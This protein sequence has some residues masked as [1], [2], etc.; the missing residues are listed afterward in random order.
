MSV[1]ALQSY[2]PKIAAWLNEVAK[3]DLEAL[4]EKLEAMCPGTEM[5][6]VRFRNINMM[7]AGDLGKLAE[8]E[9]AAYIDAIASL[10]EAEIVKYKEKTD[11]SFAEKCPGF[12]MDASTFQ[13]EMTFA[14]SPGFSGLPS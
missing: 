2:E 1:Q 6:A 11:I 8:P 7:I 9:K 14:F 5:T 3:V 12:E 10:D 4:P 13:K